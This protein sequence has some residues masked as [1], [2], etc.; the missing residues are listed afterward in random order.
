MFAKLLKI[1]H[2]FGTPIE[3]RLSKK[4]DLKLLIAFCTA[5][6]NMLVYFKTHRANRRNVNKA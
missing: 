6:G 3:L 5:S 4:G 1:L 2:D